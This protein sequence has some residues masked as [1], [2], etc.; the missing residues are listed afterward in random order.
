MKHARSLLAAVLALLFTLQT[1]AQIIPLAVESKP[2]ANWAPPQPP[3]QRLTQVDDSRASAEKPQQEEITLDIGQWH[4]FKFTLT[5]PFVVEAES[6]LS[7]SDA[8][9]YQDMTGKAVV[10]FGATDS[11]PMVQVRVIQENRTVYRALVTINSK[12]QPPTPS[13]YIA[14]L[15]KVFL[16]DT[17]TLQD[18]QTLQK[19]YT[20]AIAFTE[21][22]ATGKEVWDRINAN[23][24]PMGQQLLLLRR[25]IA[26]ILGDTTAKWYTTSL[27]PPIR[28]QYVK[29]L[30][31]ILGALQALNGQPGPVPPTP[32]GP[33]KLYMVIVEEATDRTPSRAQLFE[34][35]GL[36]QRIKDKGH[37]YLLIDKDV[38]TKADGGPPEKLKPYLERA[39]GKTLPWVII[40]D[41]TTGVELGSEQLP[42]NAADIIKLIEKAGG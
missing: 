38:I 29:V 22:A 23:Y 10:V 31:D 42:G 32:V 24:V 13:P 39:R 16:T 9:C 21:T 37:K 20:D 2:T 26:L 34:D 19:A 3:S 28:K 17:G 36:Q 40:V 33:H 5:K 1:Q 8:P 6:V 14:R 11:P 12:P 4:V 41:Q 30:Q 35:A 25:E 7:T 27:T 15:Q 18:V